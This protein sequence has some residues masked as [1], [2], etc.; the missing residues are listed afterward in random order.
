MEILSKHFSFEHY[1]TQLC[2]WGSRIDQFATLP[3]LRGY[4]WRGSGGGLVWRCIRKYSV[5]VVSNEGE[6]KSGVARRLISQRPGEHVAHM[7]ITRCEFT[8]RCTVNRRRGAFACGVPRN[9]AITTSHD[10]GH[11]VWGFSSLRSIRSYLGDRS[12]MNLCVHF[13]DPRSSMYSCT[14]SVPRGEP[15]DLFG[16]TR[17]VLCV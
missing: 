3:C 17:T 13:A 2:R 7:C 12:W 9:Y 5:T 16:F 6:K 10:A 15:Q 1:F 4:R 14:D 8:R 11:F